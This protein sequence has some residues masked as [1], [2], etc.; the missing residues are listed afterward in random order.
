MAVRY[1]DHSLILSGGCDE[2][3]DELL[4]CEVCEC[5]FHLNDLPAPKPR[6]SSFISSG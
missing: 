3:G 5:L 1:E 4:E 2:C 6:D